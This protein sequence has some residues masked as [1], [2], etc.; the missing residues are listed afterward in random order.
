LFE[1]KRRCLRALMGTAER[2]EYSEKAVGAYF[3]G[4]PVERVVD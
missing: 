1:E 4:A 3:C 2:Y